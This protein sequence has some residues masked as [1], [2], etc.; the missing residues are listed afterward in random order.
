[1]GFITLSIF[2]INK[3]KLFR[4]NNKDFPKQSEKQQ[5]FTVSLVIFS[6]YLTFLTSDPFLKIYLEYFLVNFFSS[7]QIFA[8][9]EKL[10]L[11]CENHLKN[12]I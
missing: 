6:S 2:L 12:L 8:D 9:F 11:F 5:F 1:M 10:I 4:S 3:S 7:Q